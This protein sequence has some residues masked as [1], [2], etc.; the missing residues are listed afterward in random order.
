MI[1]TNKL[2]ILLVDDREE[3]LLTLES[4]LNSPEFNLVK[5][6]SGDEALRYLLENEPALILM[7]VQMP[8][9]DGFETAT[10]IKKS[11]RTRDIPIIF[12][13]AI[14]KDEVY[15]QKGYQ[16][17]AVDY[18]YK[19][20][21]ANIL[22]S[23]VSV[24]VDL[25]RKTQKLLQVEKRIL[26]IERKEREQQIL[27]LELRSL[28]REQAEK[29]RYMDLVEGITNGIVWSADPDSL[30]TTFVSPSA[31]AILGYPIEK[32]SSEKS[33]LMNH[34]HPDDQTKFLA[35][36]QR[37]KTENTLVGL[38]HRFIAAD[39]REVWLHTGL[40]IAQL[41]EEK[42]RHIRGLSV[43]ITKIKEAEEVLKQSKRRSDF[44][45]E[46]SL[47]LSESLDYSETLSQVSRIAVPA[48]A[49][50]FAI[51][52]I[53]DQT[54][55]LLTLTHNDPEK[56]ASIKK[57]LEK[58]PPH[59]NSPYGVLN[60]FRT[61]KSEFH[62]ILKDEVLQ[63]L[64]QSKEHLDIMRGVGPKSAILVPLTT[65][66]KTFGV[67][68][69][70]SAESGY[71]YEENDL[72][73]AEDLARRA[74]V[75]IDNANFY[76]QAQAAI[77][78]RDDFLSVASHELKTPLTPLKLQTQILMRALHN[79]SLEGMMPEKLEKILQTSDR[80]LDRLS[81][82]IDEL[83]DVSR[84]SNGKFRLN[85]EEFDLTALTRDI[86]ER[87]GGQL[88][89]SKCTVDLKA[90]KDPVVVIWDQFRIEQVL[91]N[92]L[93]NAM[94]YGA[95]KPIHIE[96]KK[97]SSFVDVSVRDHGIGIKKVDQK[98]IFE[99]FERAVTGNHFSGLGLG[100][101]IV[102]EALQAHGG[103][104]KV[105]SVPEQGSTFTFSL[106][107]HVPQEIP[108]KLPRDRL[109]DGLQKVSI[110]PHATFS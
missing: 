13:T 50:W 76:Q 88:A 78:V 42:G 9:L 34:I 45:S 53:E 103:K 74:A 77:R 57:I 8:R 110:D 31:E 80:Q 95:G 106:P 11:E 59:K 100:L 4:V 86:L 41:G 3:N 67:M 39:H 66:G 18:I 6:K 104:I 1:N 49:D 75:A 91:I 108:Q 51:H 19:P 96:I 93:T 109:Q 17:G 36:L 60:V 12:I 82:L 63:D 43:E 37:L 65:H 101:Y 58:Y 72:K 64:A 56:T 81:F 22:K 70:I 44:L 2:D 46:A 92:L 62:P 29:Q 35:A 54:V 26:Q 97:T 79:G 83:L 68:T 7:D 5:A 33:F 73:M 21:D 52:V 15:T 71:L 87:F 24:F 90:P 27:Q 102:A 84:I 10:I 14:N 20:Y 48:L 69:L 61:G 99:R 32:W 28:K 38:E 85:V 40:R 23:K 16:H 30:T 55:K 89:D 105:E 94:K 25:A 107:I 98:R 47:V